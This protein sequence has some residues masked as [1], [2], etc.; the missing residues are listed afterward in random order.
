LDGK[1]E[2][3]SSEGAGTRVRIELPLAATNEARAY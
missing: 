2:I 1:L 3:D